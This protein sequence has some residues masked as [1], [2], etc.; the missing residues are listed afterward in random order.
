L[1]L[2]NVK[3]VIAVTDKV[4]AALGSNPGYREEGEIGPYK[5][6]QV[7]QGNG[8]YVVPLRYQPALVTD[9]DWKRLAYDWFQK[10]EWLEVPLLFPR[11]GDTVPP[12]AVPFRDLME[13]PVKQVLSPECH[14]KDALSNEEVQFET[15]CPGRPHLIK[16]SYHPKWRVEGAETIYLASPAFMVV[17]PTSRH[18]RLVF[19]NRWPDYVGRAATAIGIVWLMAQAM[20]F[21]IRRR[22]LGSPPMDPLNHAQ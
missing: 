12:G 17:Y 10:P 7:R 1:E 8:Q 13:G 14:V 11:P 19:G 4:K 22:Y 18:V 3:E 6:F 16:I 5:I 9:G 2:F 20:T 21:R 15:E